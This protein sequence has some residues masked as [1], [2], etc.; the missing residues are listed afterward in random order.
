MNELQQQ[1]NLIEINE[2]KERKFMNNKSTL[3]KLTKSLYDLQTL[4]IQ[5]GNRI[6]INFR[7]KL[8][9][10]PGQKLEDKEANKIL[11]QI[12][13]EY[14][15]LTD[16]IV[17]LTDKTIIKLLEKHEGVISDNIEFRLV[18]NYINLLEQEEFGFDTLKFLLK[19]FP[20]YNEFL[21]EIKGLGPKISSVIIS[22]LDPHDHVVCV[23][24]DPEKR[25][26]CGYDVERN[27]KEPMYVEHIYPNYR[28]RILRVS[29]CPE[30]KEKLHYE[31]RYV[32]SFWKYCGLD[33]TPEGEGRSRKEKHLINTYYLDKNGEI[34]QKK[35]ITFSPFI[36]TKLTGV[37]G[38]TLLMAYKKAEK[39]D[40]LD[41]W[42]YKYGKIYY[43]YKTWLKTDERH[44][45]KSDLHQHNMA[46]RK[47]IQQ[48]LKD[49]YLKWRE[50]EGLEVRP[51]YED[52]I[53]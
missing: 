13:I 50:I 25:L 52:R 21:E 47:M 34:Q 22:E 40:E 18:Q 46:N 45:D 37:L 30:C 5:T 44:R 1:R 14:S 28:A 26:G 3:R 24:K 51:S 8:G 36:K 23:G 27:G 4:R 19:A 12:K 32:S 43:N 39:K 9:Q 16:G 2:S 6:A 15:R 31:K 49:L 41:H 10:E 17:K 35:G 38:G 48:F 20:I 33:V 53:K 29:K 7:T 11:K 42:S